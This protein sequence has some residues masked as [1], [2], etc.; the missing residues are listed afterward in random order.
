MVWPS[1]FVFRNITMILFRFVVT[2]R[3][4]LQKVFSAKHVHHVRAHKVNNFNDEILF[5]RRVPTP[6]EQR[7]TSCEQVALRIRDETE[8]PPDGKFDKQTCMVQ[9]LTRAILPSPKKDFLIKELFVDAKTITEKTRNIV[10]FRNNHQILAQGNLEKHK[11]S[12]DRR[13]ISMPIL[14]CT[15]ETRRN[16]LHMWELFDRTQ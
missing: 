11:N 1:L 5:E 8:R 15:R 6:R 16:L 7:E 2:H 13:N 4:N 10:L 3:N 14:Q 12:A 9:S